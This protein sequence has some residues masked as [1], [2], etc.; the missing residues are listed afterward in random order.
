MELPITT[1][2]DEVDK[3]RHL[4]RDYTDL[5]FAFA[6]GPPHL[7]TDGLAWLSAR[8]LDTQALTRRVLERLRALTT[9]TTSDTPEHLQV[10]TTVAAIARDTT[11]AGLI[12]TDAVT[13]F[14]LAATARHPH[15][16]DGAQGPEHHEEQDRAQQAVAEKLRDA[17][18][19]LQSCATACLYAAAP[20]ANNPTGP[21][22]ATSSTP[23]AEAAD[24][25]ASAR[26]P[27]LTVAQ[28]NALRAIAAG[29]VTMRDTG[30]MGNMRITAGSGV[31]ITLS[32]YEALRRLGLVDRDT[33]TSL[34]NGQKLYATEAGR[35]AAAA[36]PATT[37]SG[38]RPAPAPPSAER[39]R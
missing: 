37:S 6:D 13:A 14:P 26:S 34:Y 12:L 8:V 28:T 3:L 19:T 36:L 10:L 18:R 21:A 11:E 39:H 16:G 27:Q 35:T 22:P 29:G 5:L 15:P 31:R 4:S 38:A 20:L 33:S 30:H 24:A 32:T 2:N 23:V 25:P 9:F 1:V 7:D 17:S